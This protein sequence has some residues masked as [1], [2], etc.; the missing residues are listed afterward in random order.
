MIDKL[1]SGKYNTLE[2]ERDRWKYA[3]EQYNLTTE[4]EILD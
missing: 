3:L 4:I 2:F 1:K